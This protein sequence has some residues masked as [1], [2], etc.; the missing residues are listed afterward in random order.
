MGELDVSGE[1]YLFMK[2]FV[3]NAA[4]DYDFHFIDLTFTDIF[5][6]LRLLSNGSGI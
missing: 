5:I 2:N 3:A 1:D 6:I 4:D